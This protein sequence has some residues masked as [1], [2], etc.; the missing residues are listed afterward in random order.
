MTPS[1]N[2][3]AVE[4]LLE[5]SPHPM[6]TPTIAK[7]LSLTVDQVRNA[8]RG[9]RSTGRLMNDVSNGG[10]VYSLSVK[11]P[12]LIPIKKDASGLG[13]LSPAKAPQSAKNVKVIFPDGLK[14]T[15]CPSPA[16]Q[17]LQ[18][19]EWEHA[20]PEGRDHEKTPSRRGDELVAHMPP[21]AM[22]V[23]R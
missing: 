2:R 8:L 13:P 15:H 11:L 21:A 14:V 4:T 23:G 20:R 10:T 7:A 16:Y 22:C 5:A 17:K 12:K 6:S 19:T 18:A 9:I 1:P 3:I